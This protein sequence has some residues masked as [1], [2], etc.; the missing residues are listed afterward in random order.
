MTPRRSGLAACTIS[1]ETEKRKPQVPGE[2]TLHLNPCR[3]W[4][5]TVSSDRSLARLKVSYLKRL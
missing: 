1:S 4:A 5:D 2:Q 3:V